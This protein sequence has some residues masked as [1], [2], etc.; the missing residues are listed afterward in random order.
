M[1]KFTS[2]LLLSNTCYIISLTA[3]SSVALFS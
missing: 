3:H 2:W 1:D